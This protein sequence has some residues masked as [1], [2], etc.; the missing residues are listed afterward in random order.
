MKRSILFHLLFSITTII[1]SQSDFR[2]GY[3]IHI[4]GDTLKG[5]IDYRG[6]EINSQ[7]CIFKSTP[8]AGTATYFPGQISSYRISD[9]KYYVSREVELD[10][11][12]LMVFLEF[13]V[14]GEADLY[15]MPEKLFF[16][17]KQSGKLILLPNTEKIIRADGND[18]RDY[19][20][21]NKEYIGI[22]RAYMSDCPEISNDIYKVKF[23]QSDLIKI[24]SKY[25]EKICPNE[26]CVIYSK[27]PP[28]KI[29]YIGLGSGLNL[30]FVQYYYALNSALVKR[31]I[32][33]GFP[34]SLYIDIMN[35][36]NFEKF[37]YSFSGNYLMAK[38]QINDN[39]YISK[40]ILISGSC[41]Y[42]YPPLKLKPIAGL[43][44]FYLTSK[45]EID[46]T[47]FPF[48]TGRES[49]G[50]TASIGLL[51][52]LKANLRLKLVGEQQSSFS[53]SILMIDYIPIP[54][55]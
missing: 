41:N 28:K 33:L 20:K 9:G 46:I 5:L 32:G 42:I 24:T 44:I 22:L 21:Q 45:E 14:D 3:I 37:F 31:E 19:V 11:R 6:P 13:L 38:H 35:T 50:I 15:Y 4:N 1:W 54:V 12:R 10:S 55:I 52:D 16:I 26:E 39:N 30:D 27:T 53:I 40:T 48:N 34:V 2:N 7:T 43:G 49:A 17:E 25:H 29:I 8:E 47:G 36:G 23:D 18:Y 51:I